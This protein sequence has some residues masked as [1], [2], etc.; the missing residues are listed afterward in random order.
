M[1]HTLHPSLCMRVGSGSAAESL[2]DFDSLGSEYLVE[3]SADFE[4][5][6]WM[7]KLDSDRV[8]IMNKFLVLSYPVSIRFGGCPD[9]RT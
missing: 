5:R 7:R 4:S 9:M 1:S 6:S 3:R 8:S 2:H